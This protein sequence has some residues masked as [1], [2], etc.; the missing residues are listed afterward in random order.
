MREIGN[1]RVNII[2]DG[3]NLSYSK[4]IGIVRECDSV[5]V[6]FHTDTGAQY[7]KRSEFMAHMDLRSSAETQ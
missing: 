5:V 4:Y 2:L 1:S 7:C 6:A 3:T